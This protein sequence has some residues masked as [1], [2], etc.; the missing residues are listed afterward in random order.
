MKTLELIVA[1]SK[2]NVIGKDNKL[3]WNLKDDL[4]NFKRITSGKTVVMGRKTY[5]SIGRPL[6]DRKNIILTRNKELKIEGCEI[7]NSIEEVL[8]LTDE[9]IVIIGGEQVYNLFKNYV[10]IFHLT[11][12]DTIIEG[13]A[14]FEID[15]SN[16]NKVEEVSQEINERNEYSWIYRKYIKKT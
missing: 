6:P 1:Y 12:V 9:E 13:D 3:L 11:E 4:L 2:N 8:K 15:I 14:F 10:D 5:D 7:I 16:L